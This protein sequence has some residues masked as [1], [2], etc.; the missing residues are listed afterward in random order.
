M[1]IWKYEHI[2]RYE[3]GDILRE[4]CLYCPQSILKRLKDEPGG[5]LHGSSPFVSVT[6]VRACPLCGWWNAV[7]EHS[8]YAEWVRRGDEFRGAAAVLRELDKADQS[9]GINE[10]RD[11]LAAHYE[12]RFG[13]NP[14]IFEEVATSVFRDLGFRAI[15]TAYTKD[16]GIDCMLNNGTNSIGVQ[17]KCTKNVVGVEQIRALAGALQLENMTEGMFVTTSRFS[18][19]AETTA[20]KYLTVDRP[21]KIELLDAGRFFDALQIAQRTVFRDVSEIATSYDWFFNLPIYAGKSGFLR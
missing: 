7:Y 9:A 16:G 21:T 8:S 5:T 14:R 15:V 19:V 13:V 3:R 17:V 10:V 6:V 1:S 12:S 2:G 20:E 18:S 4:T 11:F